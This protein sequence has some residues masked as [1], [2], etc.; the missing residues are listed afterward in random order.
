MQVGTGNAYKRFLIVNWFTGSANK[1]VTEQGSSG[2]PLFNADKRIVGQLYAGESACNYMGGAD[3]YGRVYSSWTGNNN[4]N[5]SLKPWL[6][7]DDTG[8][9]T[10][11]GLDYNETVGI[12]SPEE[13]TA[14]ALTVY[15]NPSNGMVWFDVDALGMANYKVFDLNGR[16]V[17][18]GSTV[19]TSTSQAV[20]LT[21]L[22]S[23][24]Y[25]LQ[26]HTATRS[27]SATV[28]IK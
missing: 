26:L 23:G 22:P 5:G 8:I 16:C 6:D 11:D 4:D 18:E 20:N 1:G 9:S 7:P 2:S 24:S 13:A 27:Y 12:D 28:V 17:K 14:R 3:L 15:P 21:S 25:L 19:L 10:L